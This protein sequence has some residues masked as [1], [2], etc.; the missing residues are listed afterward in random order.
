MNS[1]ST[2]NTLTNTLECIGGVSE[3]PAA[4]Q[5]PK[6]GFGKICSSFALS[7]FLSNNFVF[8][9]HHPE[10]A[11]ETTPNT[12]QTHPATIWNRAE[13]PTECQQHSMPRNLK[14]PKNTSKCDRN[15]SLADLPRTGFWK[16]VRR[17]NFSSGRFKHLPRDQ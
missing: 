7:R 16:C 6:T 17:C 5:I 11:F 1:R 3:P 14:F 12:F 13:V 2:P 8:Q 9:E 15:P 10:C 4:T